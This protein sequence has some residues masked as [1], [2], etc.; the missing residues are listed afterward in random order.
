[1]HSKA[2]YGVMRLQWRL[3][4]EDGLGKAAEDQSRQHGKQT[5]TQ[6]IS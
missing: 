3:R 1:M 4:L 6:L 5:S 2:K